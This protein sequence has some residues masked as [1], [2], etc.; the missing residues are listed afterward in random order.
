MMTTA[1]DRRK[2]GTLTAIDKSV[3]DRLA[4]TVFNATEQLDKGVLGQ[5]DQVSLM[6][7]LARLSAF[8]ALHPTKAFDGALPRAA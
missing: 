5:A 4:Q 6:P 3:R 7:A 8:W 1:E 2:P